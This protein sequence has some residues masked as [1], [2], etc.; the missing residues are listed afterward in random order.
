M[1]RSF[2]LFISVLCY[3]VLLH[4]S[5]GPGMIKELRLLSECAQ[6]LIDMEGGRDKVR[7]DSPVLSLESSV[8]SPRVYS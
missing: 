5:F 3:P 4:R 8:E 7:R 6:D 2:L 1:P